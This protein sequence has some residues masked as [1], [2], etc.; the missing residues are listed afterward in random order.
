MGGW[1]GPSRS[2]R[3]RL[4]LEID[5][6]LGVGKLASIDVVALCLDGMIGRRLW[7]V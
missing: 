2:P 3:R 6:E 7:S 1:L 5:G 4:D